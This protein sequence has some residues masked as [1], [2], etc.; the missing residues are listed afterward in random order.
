MQGMLHHHAAN[1]NASKIRSAIITG[2]VLPR[3]Q[4]KCKAQRACELER[5]L[6]PERLAVAG[7]GGRA[8]WK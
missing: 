8:R 2:L 1:D 7:C 3:R 5:I 4:A 6:V